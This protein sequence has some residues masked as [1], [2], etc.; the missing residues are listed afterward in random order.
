[1]IAIHWMNR[2]QLN[3]LQQI[4]AER[5]SSGEWT[6]PDWLMNAQTTFF[7][8]QNR[9]QDRKGLMQA[10]TTRSPHADNP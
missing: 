10:E 9:P 1:M 3:N 6:T 8:L 2:E 4:F 5:T 7:E